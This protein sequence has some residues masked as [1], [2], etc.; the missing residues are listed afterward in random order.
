MPDAD[1][2]D[3]GAVKVERTPREKCRLCGKNASLKVGIWEI[4][5]QSETDR[6]AWRML[7]L[8]EK[9][10]EKRKFIDFEKVWDEIGF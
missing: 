8:C 7:F 9:C 5:S 1:Y 4:N 3:S 10:N 2:I 6:K